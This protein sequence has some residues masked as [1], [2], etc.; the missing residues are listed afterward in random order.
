MNR[1]VTIKDIAKILNISVST[2]SRALRNAY[3]VSQETRDKVLAAVGKKHYSSLVIGIY[4]LLL[5]FT[6]LAKTPKRI[7]LIL[8]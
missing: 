8:N 5:H 7:T 6:R 2:V 3:D 1:P 4:K